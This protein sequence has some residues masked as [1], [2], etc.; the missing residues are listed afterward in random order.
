MKLN[1][2]IVVMAFSFALLVRADEGSSGTRGGGS[3]VSAYFVTRTQAVMERLNGWDQSILDL[4]VLENSIQTQK[5]LVVDRL[6][7]PETG[8]PLANQN[9]LMAYGSRG[10]I[11]LRASAWRSKIIQGVYLDH[12]VLHELLRATGIYD[13][14]GYKISIKIFAFD[15]APGQLM[16]FDRL[17]GHMTFYDNGLNGC[18]A[19]IAH[20]A[21]TNVVSVDYHAIPG[22]ELGCLKVGHFEYGCGLSGHCGVYGDAAEFIDVISVGYFSRNGADAYFT[23][24]HDEQN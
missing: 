1:F 15:R 2:G 22:R 11:Q 6:Q 21:G 3:D 23:P 14:D 12:Q 18:V 17:S 8:K 20:V 10:L 19:R 13:D 5:I 4:H 24:F 9:D 16:P 7:D